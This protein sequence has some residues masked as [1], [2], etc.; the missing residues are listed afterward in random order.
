MGQIDHGTLQLFQA[1]LLAL[2]GFLW[3]RG[4]REGG[5]EG[6]KEGG[7]VGELTIMGGRGKQK[8]KTELR[9]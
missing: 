3:R 6:G 8:A 7:R 9:G 4:G 1:A 5:K 2:A